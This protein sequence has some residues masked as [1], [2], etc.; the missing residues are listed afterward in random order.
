MTPGKE[1][2][3]EEKNK[4]TLISATLDD[5]LNILKVEIKLEI[6][7]WSNAISVIN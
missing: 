2:E 7:N 5:N 3:E 1:E 4:Q 6:S